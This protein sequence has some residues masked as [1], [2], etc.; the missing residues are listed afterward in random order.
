MD[1][2]RVHRPR[3]TRSKP[4]ARPGPRPQTPRGMDG[5]SSLGNYTR[6]RPVFDAAF[7]GAPPPTRPP[8]RV[9][10]LSAYRTRRPLA[11]PDL[12]W[13]LER[14]GREARRGRGPG[15]GQGCDNGCSG[16]ALPAARRSL[17]LN[18][19]LP[20]FGASCR[21]PDYLDLKN[22]DAALLD[23]VQGQLQQVGP[24]GG[25]LGA[26]LCLSFLTASPLAASTASADRPTARP[27][28]PR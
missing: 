20:S 26:S 6:I 27:R 8:P 19:C 9:N 1:R 23:A 24:R 11:D 16:K 22:I 15:R 25:C 2:Q 10:R 12:F 3:H 28:A 17:P 14:G 18:G 13:V 7:F 4:A 5:V 21:S